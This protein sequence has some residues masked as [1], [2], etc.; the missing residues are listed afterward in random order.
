MG[1]L[2]IQ[3]M[4][5]YSEHGSIDYFDDYSNQ[6]QIQIQ[7]SDQ[8]NHSAKLNKTDQNGQKEEETTDISPQNNIGTEENTSV[9][10]KFD[11]KDVSNGCATSTQTVRQVDGAFHRNFLFPTRKHGVGSVSHKT[12]IFSRSLMETNHREQQFTPVNF[13]KADVGNT[14]QTPN[15]SCQTQMAMK[16]RS[17]H[18]VSNFDG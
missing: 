4:P 8:L 9:K 7:K 15:Q 18:M 5:S 2:A 13:K 16:I 10:Q 3:N 17:P 14:S 6:K 12:P 11:F 1:P